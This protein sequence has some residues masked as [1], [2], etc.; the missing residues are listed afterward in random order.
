MSSE[1]EGVIVVRAM[2]VKL[3][4]A[5][6]HNFGMTVYLDRGLKVESLD[7]IDFLLDCLR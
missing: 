3:S 1:T 4:H 5:R 6:F 2:K 7:Q